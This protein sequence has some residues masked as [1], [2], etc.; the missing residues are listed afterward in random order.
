VDRM[1]MFVG[2]EITDISLRLHPA[3]E[4]SP[5]ERVQGRKT[6]QA[7]QRFNLTIPYPKAAERHYAA[8]CN[9]DLH[10]LCRQDDVQLLRKYV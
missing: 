6:R 7:V 9:I 5:Y 2:M 4:V 10:N 3:D 1:A 8:D